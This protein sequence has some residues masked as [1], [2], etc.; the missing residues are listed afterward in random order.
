MSGPLIR[1]GRFYSLRW[2]LIIVLGA[3][4]LVCQLISVLWLW[5]ESKEQIDLL[6]DK[7]LAEAVRN[8]HVNTEI[9]EAIASLSVPSLLM[10]LVTLFFCFQAVK[11]I[12]RPL[13]QLQ[14]HLQ[15]RSAEDF[16]PL[17]ESGDINEVL[18]VTRALNHLLAR[19]NTTLQQDR[20]FTADVA[21]E[22][23]TPLAGIRLHLELHEKRHQIDCQPL[24]ERVDN[25]AFTVEQLLMLARI[26]HDFSS[27][28]YQ[29]VRL[30]ADVVLPQQ[31]ELE[32]MAAARG[33]R[34]DW[35]L[36]AA[37]PVIQGN[38]VLLRLLLRNLV[39][40]AHRYC[41]DGS[42]ITVIL[43]QENTSSGR[44]CILQVMDEGPGIDE[45][46]A[47]ELTQQF[48]RM[49][50]RYNGIGLGLSIVTRIAQLHLGRFSLGNRQDR[51]GTLARLE[52]DG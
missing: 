29:A 8:Q 48:V 51:R 24:I 13:S 52:L 50:Q 26:R 32:E 45:A 35:Q 16:Q 18:A 43:Q 44:R 4:M 30:V 47:G 36:P 19:L 34:L 27:G 38:A 11:W 6:V 9:H 7:T 3:I 49:D 2:R 28:Q 33:Q 22:L 12:T 15:N 40:N 37:D 17:P 23:R 5:H 31:G 20:Q 39:E 10:I 1:T 46:R 25:M 14:T 42:T 21:H 41:P